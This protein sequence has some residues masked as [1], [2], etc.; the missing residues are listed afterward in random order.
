MNNV[1]RN[2]RSPD[3]DCGIGYQMKLTC[4]SSPNSES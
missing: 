3:M 4:K 1:Q 2:H